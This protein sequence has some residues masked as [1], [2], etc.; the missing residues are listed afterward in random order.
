MPL[1]VLLHQSEKI[2]PVD[3]PL[4]SEVLQQMAADAGVEEGRMSVA[5]LSDPEIREVNRSYLQH[6]YETDVISFDL[7]DDDVFLDGELVLSADTARRMANDVGWA[8]QAELLLYAIH[9]MLHVLGYEDD[10]DEN[11]DEMR[12]MEAHYLKRFR[13]QGWE[14]HPTQGEAEPD[15]KVDEKG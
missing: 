4:L 9:G 10:T 2:E 5:I 14:K 7:S 8:P 15:S 11:R 6:D 13:I 12:R 1:Q 3:V